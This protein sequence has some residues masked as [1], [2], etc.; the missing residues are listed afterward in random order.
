M[1]NII[2]KII[3]KNGNK[4]NLEQINIANCSI[5]THLL[6]GKNDDLAIEIL[7]LCGDRYNFLHI[8]DKK[9]NLL[10]DACHY[11]T[12]K[13]AIILIKKYGDKCGIEQVNY[14]NET[15]L[16]IACKNKLENLAIKLIKKYDDKCNY[17]KKN[18]DG[19]TAYD[20]AT[21]NNLLKVIEL[22][23]YTKIK[24]IYN[25]DENKCSI[26]MNDL[27]DKH[28]LLVGCGHSCFCFKCSVSIIECAICKI[29]IIDRYELIVK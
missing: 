12:E 6:C 18:N 23:E 2:R 19:K 14:L 22:L 15:A 24:K 17:N 3:K 1:F 5:F 10:L 27:N 9:Y 16:I 8:D 11:Q 4:Y 29:K 21:E 20:F 25:Y 26:C 13:F 28:I 7:K